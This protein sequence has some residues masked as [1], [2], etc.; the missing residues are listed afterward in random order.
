MNQED[1]IQNQFIS[2]LNLTNSDQLALRDTLN[3]FSQAIQTNPNDF[4][5]YVELGLNLY[6]KCYLEAS[7]IAYEYAVTLDPDDAKSISSPRRRLVCSES[8]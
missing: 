3:A 4:N 6:Q 1:I 7:I 5:T 8:L 2:S